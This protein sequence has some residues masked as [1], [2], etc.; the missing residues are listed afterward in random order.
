MF[1]QLLA[2]IVT[3]FITCSAQA[4][5]IQ[6]YNN[7]P[8]SGSWG[9]E[10]FAHNNAF[11]DAWGSIDSL[12]LDL[13]VHDIDFTTNLQTF[14][15]GSWATVGAFGTGNNIWKWYNVGL[16]SNVISE[17]QST[18]SLN[19]R[20]NEAQSSSWSATYDQ[21]KLT[22]GYTQSQVPEPASIALLGLGLV[23]L[24]FSRKKKSA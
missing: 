18:G 8:N 22:I 5:V 14:V 9:F 13:R 24:R 4:L 20:F 7:L 21:S 6:H 2:L 12:E 10:H 23:G 19:F 1:K 17:L 15:A 16:G 11:D 3:L